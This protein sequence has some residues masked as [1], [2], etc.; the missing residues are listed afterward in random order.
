MSPLCALIVVIGVLPQT[1]I[2]VISPSVES[3]MHLLGH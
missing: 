2:G 3:I 1:L